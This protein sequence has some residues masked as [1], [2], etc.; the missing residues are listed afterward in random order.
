MAA[1]CISPLL[2]DY[3]DRRPEILLKSLTYPSSIPPMPRPQCAHVVA[4][5][6]SMD[7]M[8]PNER[9]TRYIVPSFHHHMHQRGDERLVDV[10]IDYRH[11]FRGF[12]I[13]KHG[14]REPKKPK[15]YLVT[16]GIQATGAVTLRV[17]V[18]MHMKN[19][20]IRSHA[21]IT[22]TLTAGHDKCHLS[23][24]H[25]KQENNGYRQQIDSGSEHAPSRSR[26]T[27]SF[28]DG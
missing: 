2:S 1:H 12:K 24:Q 6:G 28:V 14:D 21:G 13:I 23:D 3:L 5:P 26:E 4:L 16:V 19:G 25:A 9:L 11:E 8:N 15:A 17:S 22:H 18:P 10:G 20:I 7:Q 27:C